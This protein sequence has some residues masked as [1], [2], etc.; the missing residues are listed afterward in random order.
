MSRGHISAAIVLKQCCG[1]VGVCSQ[2]E[3]QGRGE[4]LISVGSLAA[5]SSA[6]PCCPILGC[7]CLPILESCSSR[8]GGKTQD[9]AGAVPGTALA[10]SA[11]PNV[12]SSLLHGSLA[13]LLP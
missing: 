5:A 3:V 7:H 4:E 11:L 10:T 8:A 1:A 9:G 6:T 2:G 13:Q 12:G